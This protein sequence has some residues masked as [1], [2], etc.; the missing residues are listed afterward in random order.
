VKNGIYSHIS[1]ADYHGGQGI[2]KSGLDLIGRSP[3]HYWNAYLNP[4]REPR[5]ST[6]AMLL[7]TLI[8]TAILEPDLFD[9]QYIAMPDF[10]RR[11][12]EGKA[13][14]AAFEAEI[15]ASGK[16]ACQE[17]DLVRAKTIAEAVYAQPLARKLLMKGQAE[18]SI[19]W[20]DEETGVLCK[21]RPDFLADFDQVGFPVQFIVDVKSTADASPEEFKRSAYKWKYHT[22]AAWYLDGV[23][24]ATG[25]RPDSFIF[26]VVEKDPP[27]AVAFYFADED[28][29]LAGRALYRKQLRT[30]AECAASNT[31]HGYEAKVLPLGLPRW[32]DIA[33]EDEE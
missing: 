30:F 32:A 12:N 27:F 7:G 28:Q 13:S 31:W 5:K 10:N 8:H 25:V 18:Q 3:L 16:M 17:A 24:A 6:P 20:T 19:Y 9:K 23:E 4:N 1:N 29:L 33:S 14:A 21:C 26:L 15:A 22:Q 11:T 2:S